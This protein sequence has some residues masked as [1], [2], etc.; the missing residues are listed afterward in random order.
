MLL[1]FET[2]VLQMRLRRKS[3]PNFELFNPYKIKGV[4]D[5]MCMLILPV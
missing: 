1:H 3:M 2:M 4:M 5:E